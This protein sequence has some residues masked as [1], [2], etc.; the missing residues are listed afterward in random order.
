MNDLTIEDPLFAKL[1]FHHKWIEVG[2][3]TSENFVLIKQEYLKGE[4][5]FS[6]HYRWGAF[7]KFMKQNKSI[8][9]ASFYLLYDLG[10]NDADPGMGRS[11]LFDIINRIDCPLELIDRAIDTGDFTLSK[12][13]VKRKAIRESISTNKLN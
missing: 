5:P 9:I 11:I 6:E 4:D 13:A 2:I 10:E 3:I 12:H 8:D 7:H 1:E